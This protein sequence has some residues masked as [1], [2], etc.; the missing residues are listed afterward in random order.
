[1]SLMSSNCRAQP[2][3]SQLTMMENQQLKDS[4]KLNSQPVIQLGPCVLG[5]AVNLVESVFH[6][7]ILCVFA[8]NM[9]A[10]V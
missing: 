9:I 6:L 8:A 10:I 2:Q 1:M 3:F 4:T 5:H 7:E